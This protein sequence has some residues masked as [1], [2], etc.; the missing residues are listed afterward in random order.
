PA[1]TTPTTVPRASLA[2]ARAG[3]SAARA[4]G[5]RSAKSRQTPPR[6]PTT[7]AVMPIARVPIR[8]VQVALIPAGRASDM[9]RP[10]FFGYPSTIG[11]L[12]DLRARIVTAGTSEIGD[13][14]SL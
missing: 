13:E 1:C 9:P 11:K 3:V 7:G 5:V 8:T 2:T 10:A 4:P 12:Q 6:R 14:S